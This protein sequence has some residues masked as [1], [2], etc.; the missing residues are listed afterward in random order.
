MS[1][2]T[3]FSLH[4][5]DDDDDEMTIALYYLVRVSPEKL[6]N[7][8]WRKRVEAFERCFKTIVVK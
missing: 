3:F 7:N 1:I 6:L 5:N 8:S 2:V 4:D